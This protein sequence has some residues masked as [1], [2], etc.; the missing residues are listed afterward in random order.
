MTNKPHPV[1]VI[2]GDSFIRKLKRL[3]KKFPHIADD[4]QPV[5][6]QLQRGETPGDQ[7]PN[8][9]YTVYKVRIPNRDAKRGKSGGYRV[10]YYLKTKTNIF[11]IAIYAKS[12][13]EDISA[14]EL[15]KLIQE[16]SA[17]QENTSDKDGSPPES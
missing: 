7:I 10:I 12:E 13:S 2:A 8:V 14:E 3:H 4:V 15:R 1:R 16:V 6:D 9:G 11:L 5:T 17:E